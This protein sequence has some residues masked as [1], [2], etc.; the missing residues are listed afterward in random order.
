MTRATQ[1][2]A[3]VAALVLALVGAAGAQSYPHATC[4]A[5]CASASDCVFTT[6]GCAACNASPIP[7]GGLTCGPWNRP[8]L[9]PQPPGPATCRTRCHSMNPCV[10]NASQPNF[11]GYCRQVP[12]AEYGYCGVSPAPVCK[13]TSC[14]SAA[15]CTEAPCSFCYVPKGKFYGT[16]SMPPT[17]SPPPALAHVTPCRLANCTNCWGTFTFKVG[18]CTPM[19]LNNASQSAVVTCAR[20]GATLTV[21]QFVA[22]GTACSGPK[23][24]ATFPTARCGANAAGFGGPQYKVINYDCGY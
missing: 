20:D 4:G 7:F 15:A 5:Q 2:A 10:G 1:R 11:C 22:N 24:T 16:C 9:P 8:T 18:A 14:S 13:P 12:A 19:F 6:D 21:E 17:P 23:V 3:V